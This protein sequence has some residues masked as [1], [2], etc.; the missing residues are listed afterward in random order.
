VI[1]LPHAPTDVT[2]TNLTLTNSSPIDVLEDRSGVATLIISHPSGAAVQAQFDSDNAPID[3]S[4][5]I[6][7]GVYTVLEISKATRYMT[8]FGNGATRVYCYVV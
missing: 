6:P 5:S 4:D 3:A 1:E 8:L 7:L 2:R